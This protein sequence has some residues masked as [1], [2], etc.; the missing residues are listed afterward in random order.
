MYK[1]LLIL[2]FSSL[3]SAKVYDG[4]AV[5]VKDKA[6]TLFDIKKEMQLSRVNASVATDILIRKKLEA[7]EIDE[8]KINILSTE[9]YDDIKMMAS[10]NKMSLS[11]FY[12]AVRESNGLSSTELKAKVKQKLLSQKLY[13][14]IAYSSLSEPNDAEVKEYY[15]LH[16][17]SFKHPASFSVIIYDAKDKNELQT[18]INNPMFYSPNIL[19]NEQVLP[20]EKISP[21][22]ASLLERTPLNH[23]TSVV[24]NGKGGF[25]SFYM[26][27]IESTQEAGIE[28]V[29][30]QIINAIMGEKREQVLGD[31]FARLKHNADI[32]FIREVE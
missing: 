17:S 27:E 13:S 6:I 19:T 32:N 11:D 8:R 12:D 15:E 22:L 14:Q 28:S 16:K 31:Y 18:K 30:N 20:Y 4:V 29:R 24:P 26:K 1:S 5:V 3:L 9:V 10:R 2:L 23:F 25:M 7:I 21:E